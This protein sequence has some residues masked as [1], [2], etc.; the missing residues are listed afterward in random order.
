MQFTTQ[1]YEAVRA[2]YRKLAK[3]N[4]TKVG[5]VFSKFNLYVIV[6]FTLILPVVGL[7]ANIMRFL[8]AL[9]LGLL[10]FFVLSL[11]AN[12]TK[13]QK[14][15]DEFGDDVLLKKVLKDD[16][17]VV[18]PIDIRL[19]LVEVGDTPGTGAAAEAVN[20]LSLSTQRYEDRVTSR[21]RQARRRA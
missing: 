9:P 12:A 6:P 1:E 17:I 21:Y 4:F 20:R 14:L 15:S 16:A 8:W 2:E 19:L 5:G 10:A 3:Q 18:D 7:F 11:L 13:A